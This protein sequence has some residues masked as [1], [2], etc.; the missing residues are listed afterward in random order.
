M[1]GSSCRRIY[2]TEF[3]IDAL[4]WMDTATKTKAAHDAIAAGALSPNEARFKYFGLG[5]VPGGETPYLQQ[6]MFSL[7]ALAERDAAQ[8]FAK[9]APPPRPC[10]PSPPTK[11]LRPPW[12]R[13]R[14]HD[15]PRVSRASSF[16]VPLLSLTAAK[17]HLRITDTT[18]DTEITALVAA[19]QEHVI[20][21]LKAAADPTWTEATVPLVVQHAIKLMLDA[22]NERR[23]G[24]EAADELRKT[25]ETVDLLLGLYKDPTIA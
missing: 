13:S 23:G 15:G 11:T 20:T 16:T 4:I 6:Q 9:P 12:A 5:P 21:G 24:A 8:P 3:D 14:T 25:I 22:F 18:H 7:A 1:K 2:G 17:Q 19:A 10:P